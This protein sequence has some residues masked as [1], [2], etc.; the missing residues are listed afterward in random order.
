MHG[1]ILIEIL[2]LAPMGALP[3]P[4]GGVGLFSCLS[5]SPGD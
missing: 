1:M 4:R 5:Y 2:A 3:H